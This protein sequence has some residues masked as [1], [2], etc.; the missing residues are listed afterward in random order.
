MRVRMVCPWTTNEVQPWARFLN[1]HGP[2]TLEP[3]RLARLALATA[4]LATEKSFEDLLRA[5]AQVLK[6]KKPVPAAKLSD[7]SS[8]REVHQ[9]LD[10]K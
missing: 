2:V 8:R 3:F 7:F 4:G 6:L 5:D 9:E 10:L 1:I